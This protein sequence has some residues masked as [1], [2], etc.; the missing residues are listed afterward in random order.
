M[1]ILQV[2]HDFLPKHRAGA[3]IYACNLCSRL[4]R[5]NHIHLF[6]T[7]HEPAR[8][9]YSVDYG[10]YEGLSYTRVI[11]NHCLRSF[12]ET[13][14]NPAMDR[15]FAELL[16]RER[17][18]V[19]HFQHLLFHSVNYIDIAVGRGIPTVATLHDFWPLCEQEGKRI[20][21]YFE[22]EDGADG[23]LK[24]CADIDAKL[25][26]R[27]LGCRPT[28]AS[29]RRRWAYRALRILRAVTRMDF[30]GPARR[31]SSA[32]PGTSGVDCTGPG[33]APD[34]ISK[35]NDYIRNAYSKIDK[36]IAP[37]PFLKWEF[38]KNGFPRER[39][40]RADYGFDTAPFEGFSRRPGKGIRFGY[41]GTVGELKGVHVLIE[42]FDKLAD[43]EAT[44][45][46]YGGM[47]MYPDYARRVKSL[48]AGEGVTFHGA[49]SP[50]RVVE[51]FSDIDV[52]VAP[53]I[54]YENSPLVIHEA[55]MSATPVITTNLGGMA[56]L[57][58]DNE[59]GLLFECGNAADLA[60]RMGRLVSDPALV[61]KLSLGAP[62]V[63]TID[64]DAADIASI[65]RA[66]INRGDA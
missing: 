46:I 40:I 38:E 1:R 12:E 2:I 51:I 21:P 8:R 32:V 3:E 49:F 11:N 52:L 39:I 26:G 10:D 13:Y 35:R 48:V 41:V 7:E 54:W 17:P 44:L 4:S 63:K 36:I 19:I 65:Y 23:G 42:A 28:I 56:D 6:F 59:S 20:R 14:D 50:D 53:S 15:I 29:R 22:G 37:S 55:F 25:C 27:C 33:I 61:K 57:V 9:Q 66:L 24:I 34:R 62:R 64:E 45:H 58:S 43:S 31:L 18:D 5:E 30:T 16:D 60:E 47:D